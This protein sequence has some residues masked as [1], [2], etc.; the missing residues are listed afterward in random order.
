[1]AKK[2]NVLSQEEINRTKLFEEASESYKSI[3]TNK[4]LN[5]DA[6]IKLVENCI[7]LTEYDEKV[8]WTHQII[9]NTLV[10]GSRNWYEAIGILEAC[11]HE[12][13][14]ICDDI[15]YQQEHED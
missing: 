3:F 15:Q 2:T 1:M 14:S 4:G 7:Q 9:F 5:L 8:M 6:L 11:K 13:Q 10:T 12:Y